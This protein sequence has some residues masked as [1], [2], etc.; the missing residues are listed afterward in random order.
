M[1]GLVRNIFKILSF[2]VSLLE[3]EITDTIQ[4]QR[5]HNAMEPHSFLDNNYGLKTTIPEI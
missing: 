3:C 1:A 2:I 5:E 4:E